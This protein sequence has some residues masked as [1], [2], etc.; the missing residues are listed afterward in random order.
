MGW[1]V[2]AMLFIKCESISKCILNRD[3]KERKRVENEREKTW[4]LERIAE[5]MTKVVCML[6]CTSIYTSV[7]VS[8][9][10]SQKLNFNGITHGK[11][12]LEK[13]KKTI[14]FYLYFFFVGK[15]E[16]KCDIEKC[17]FRCFNQVK[18]KTV[19]N[20]SVFVCLN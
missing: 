17:S 13:R 10:V 7:H 2:F 9:L 8:I 19:L 12:R 14:I 4:L 20:L 16:E 1:L 5:N 18:I 6:V 15:F 3:S 11:E